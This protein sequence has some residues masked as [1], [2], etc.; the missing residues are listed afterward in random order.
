MVITASY[1]PLVIGGVAERIRSAVESSTFLLNAHD[2][3]HITLSIGVSLYLP[4]MTLDKAI[5]M[6]D[7]ALYE[8]KRSGKIGW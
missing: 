3:A 5:A 2:E 8:A 4:G 1:D 6:T 7:E